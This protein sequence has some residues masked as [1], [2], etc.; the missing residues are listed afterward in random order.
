MPA[1]DPFRNAAESLQRAID[2]KME[3]VRQMRNQ[4]ADLR[5]QADT[6]D[7]EAGETEKL[8]NKERQQITELNQQAS[9]SDVTEKRLFNK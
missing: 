3:Q 6:L 8:V 7:R 2:V 9:I 1:G 5:K 4:A